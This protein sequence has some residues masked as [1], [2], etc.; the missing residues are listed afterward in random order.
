MGGAAFV[1]YR[2][3]FTLMG[4]SGYLENL[5]A[6]LIAIAA[7][8]VIY[9]TLVLV[10]RILSRDDILLLPAGG[11]ILRFLTKLGLYS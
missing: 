4:G 5:A 6:S 11:K 10:F 9:I 8:A 1:I 3:L 2:L 7:A